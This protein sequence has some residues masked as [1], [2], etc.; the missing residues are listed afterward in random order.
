MFD[1]G[2][3]G[4]GSSHDRRGA[5]VCIY[6]YTIEHIS[7][8]LFNPAY[9][10]NAMALSTII[11]SRKSYL[12]SISLLLTV[13][14]SI[15]VN[16]SLDY[17][18]LLNASFTVW[19]YSPNYS[20]DTFPPYP[21]LTH[22]NGTNIDVQALRGTRLYGWKGCE[23]QE[24][25][26]LAQAYDDFYKLAQQTEVYNNIVWDDQAAKEFFGPAFGVNKIPDARRKQIQRKSFSFDC[27]TT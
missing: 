22:A 23:V 10:F 8:L 19:E 25:K 3:I 15:I 2:I 20:N 14:N 17:A 16:A 6:I 7:V 24:Q 4:S 18:S 1:L 5:K 9:S 12:I 11:S 13:S 27:T 26:D 21:P